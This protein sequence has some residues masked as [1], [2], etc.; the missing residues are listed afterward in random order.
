MTQATIAPLLPCS[1]DFPKKL[2]EIAGRI[3]IDDFWMGDGSGGRRTAKLGIRKIYEDMGLEKWYN[4]TAYKVVLR[5]IE[6]EIKDTS[7][8]LGV[9]KSGFKPD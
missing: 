9:S 8:E 5:M 1:K 7:I 6:E 3:T 4:P 2:K